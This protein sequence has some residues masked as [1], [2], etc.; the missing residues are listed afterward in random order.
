MDTHTCAIGHRG[1]ANTVDVKR[2]T[3]VSL[4]ILGPKSIVN[5]FCILPDIGRD[6]RA[7]DVPQTICDIT[8]A[9]ALTLRTRDGESNGLSAR[10]RSWRPEDDQRHGN[11]G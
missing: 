11:K 5:P 3:K 8:A 9:E 6:D 7:N 4:F 10:G 2:N 1:L